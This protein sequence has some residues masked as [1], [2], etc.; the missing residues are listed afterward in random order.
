MTLA[1][2]PAVAAE[3]W[4]AETIADGL[5]NPRG[6]AVAPDGT[7]YVA[8]S[9]SGGTTSNEDVAIAGP[10]GLF[11][12]G[13]TGS[14]TKIEFIDGAKVEFIDATRDSGTAATSRLAAQFPSVV[15]A[16]GDSCDPAP[17][18]FA[19]T[20]P[21]S[22]AV[23]EDGTLI[24]AMGMGGPPDN[25]DVLGDVFGSVF[26]VVA[27]VLED[28]IANIPAYVATQ[29]ALSESNPYGVALVPEGILVVDAGADALFLIRNDST[30]DTV[31]AFPDFGQAPV[32]VLSCG[33]NS[34]PPVGTMVNIS[35][36][37]TAV[38]IGPEGD[39]F[40]GFL[41]GEPY[42]P[43]ASKVLKISMVEERSEPTIYVDNL[44]QITGLAFDADG[45]LYIS[46]L[47]DA[48]ILEFEV[49]QSNPPV[50]GSV[51]KVDTNGNRETIGQ[52]P[53]VNDV[54]VDKETGAVYVA[55]NSIFSNAVGGGSIVKLTQP[56]EN[57]GGEPTNPPD[58]PSSGASRTCPWFFC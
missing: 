11:C 24:V 46:Q 6:V 52:F 47:S 30:I 7:V 21:S 50:N 22:L 16:Q 43:G 58:M 18:G 56:E 17:L 37:P 51:I 48:S 26:R 23:E 39:Y 28:N 34:T 13:P 1:A 25:Q 3:N 14:I 31:I 35:S 54:A 4:V 38:A 57:G 41:T 15:G 44:T 49:C 19:A 40:V 10:P 55:V 36:V 12:S 5:N 27:E 29:S 8:E 42:A 45:S 9:G 53:Y 20:G 32:P 2:V 33:N